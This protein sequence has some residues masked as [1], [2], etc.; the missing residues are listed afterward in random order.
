VGGAVIAVAEHE[1]ERALFALR[2]RR[3][4][5]EITAEVCRGLEAELRERYARELRADLREY[6]DRERQAL[7]SALRWEARQAD[8]EE[9]ER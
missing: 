7:D 6:A 5:G 9:D 3:D 1:L 2:A 4:A 8:A